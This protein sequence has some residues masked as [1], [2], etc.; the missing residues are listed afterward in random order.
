MVL[1]RRQTTYHRDDHL[2]PCPDAAPKALPL[3]LG[4]GLHEAIEVQPEG[5]HRDPL[6]RN[7]EIPAE[8]VRLSRADGDDLSGEAREDSLDRQEEKRLEPTEVAVKH[9]PVERVHPDRD[10]GE[11]GRQPPQ[12]PCLCGVRVYDFRPCRAEQ[13]P[14]LPQRH[15]VVEWPYGPAELR[16]AEQLRPELRGKSRHVGLATRDIAGYEDRGVVEPG[17][18]REEYH[19]PG[20]TADIEPRNDP[21]NAR[22]K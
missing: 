16:Y 20:R 2:R 13:P 9:M 18:G 11:P 3:G 12:R 21:Y 4:V 7:P 10:P 15:E 8:I 22:P 5:D 17:A 14:Q 1:D 6:R 19:V